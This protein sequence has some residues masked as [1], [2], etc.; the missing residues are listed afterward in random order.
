[1][2]IRRT[3]VKGRWGYASRIPLRLEAFGSGGGTD[4]KLLREKAESIHPLAKP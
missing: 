3:R 2:A 4:N 1:M